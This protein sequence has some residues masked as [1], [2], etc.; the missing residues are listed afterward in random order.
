M[1][2]VPT[3]ERASSIADLDLEKLQTK[4]ALGVEW[5]VIE[6]ELLGRRTEEEVCLMWLWSTTP[7]GWQ[8]L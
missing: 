6:V 1:S 7:L 4:R 3:N 5:E 2:Q 8:P